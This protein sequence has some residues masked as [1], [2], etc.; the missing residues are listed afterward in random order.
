MRIIDK[1]PFLEEDG[2]IGFFNRIQGTLQH[3]F[4]WYPNLQAQQK[5]L[6]VFEKRLD[7]KFTLICNHTLGASKIT[8]PFIL[9]GPPGI[10]VFLIT[11][12]EGAYQ[13]KA[14]SWG[15]IEGERVKEAS[16]NLLKR[17][18]QFAK[19]VQVYLQKQNI[20][21]PQRV[22]PVLLALNPGLHIDSIRP[23][24]RIVMSD[25]IERF[26][27]SLSQSPPIM[28]VADVHQ[29]SE[30]VINPI[31]AKAKAPAPQP[32]ETP[33]EELFYAQP[34]SKQPAN[35]FGNIDFS[36]DDEEKSAAPPAPLEP[37]PTPAR[38]KTATKA[39]GDVLMGMTQKQL[40][41]LAAMGAALACILVLFTFAVLLFL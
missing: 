28:A 6:V 41:I 25:A 14:D 33:A 39:A 2:S 1:T 26:A 9:I 21:L 37:A 24:V 7:K 10:Y 17:T 15:V 11:N 20:E 12:L 31:R 34:A 8:V 16:I 13:A 3:G 18:A 19:A 27:A 38:N 30:V 35:D 5:A 22:E 29:I 40:I 4:S 23:L 32:V 36:F